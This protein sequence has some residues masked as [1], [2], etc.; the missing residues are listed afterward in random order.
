MSEDA[1]AKY[2]EELRPVAKVSDS[3]LP[4]NSPMEGDNGTPRLVNSSSQDEGKMVL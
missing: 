2:E 1:N 4:L 3:A